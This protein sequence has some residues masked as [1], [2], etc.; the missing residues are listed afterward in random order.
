[1]EF[2]EAIERIDFLYHKGKDEFLSEDEKQ[3]QLRLKAYYLEVIK[4]NF[5]I[6]LNQ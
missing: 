3:E 6:E 4:D 5:R 2:K 1:M